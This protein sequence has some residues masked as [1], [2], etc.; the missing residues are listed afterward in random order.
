MTRSWKNATKI[1]PAISIQPV[2]DSGT[3]TFT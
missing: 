3:V 1:V 2:D